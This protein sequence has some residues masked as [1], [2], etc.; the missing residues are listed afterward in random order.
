MPRRQGR[1]SRKKRSLLWC[2]TVWAS[3]SPSAGCAFH[4]RLTERHF[5]QAS[6]GG[7][8]TDRHSLHCCSSK[9]PSAAAAVSP[10]ATRLRAAGGSVG[11]RVRST[12]F[13]RLGFCKDRRSGAEATVIVDHAEAAHETQ[14][15]ALDLALAG[16]LRELP[17]RL[18]QPEEAPGGAGLADRELAARGVQREAAVVGEAVLAHELRPV[19]L[20]AEPE[21][22]ELH[23]GD[24]RVVVVG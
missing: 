4:R 7:Y 19:A 12:G 6:R 24:H 5:W 1:R 20:G 2:R 15:R 23:H 18:H 10:S 14:F 11:S 9:R 17:D 22:L 16:L 8:C 3:S 13:L 21:V